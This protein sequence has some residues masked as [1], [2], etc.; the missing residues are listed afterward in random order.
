MGTHAVN[1][2]EMA[3][4][5]MVLGLLL[6]MV[7]SGASA[8]DEPEVILIASHE[9]EEA[10]ASMA[11][12]VGGQLS[13]LPVTFRVEWVDGFEPLMASQVDEARALAK[14]SDAVAVIWSDLSDPSQV[15]IYIAEPHG[16]RILVRSVEPEGEVM[17]MLVEALAVIVRYAVE[18][19]IEG[20]EIGIKPPPVVKKELIEKPSH[21][22][23]RLGVA[24][25]YALSLYGPD[26][27]LLH[28][29]RVA[30]EVGIYR[31]LRGYIGYRIQPSMR[32]GDH[33]LSMTMNTHP[34]EIGI[35]M[36]IEKGQFRFEGG[37]GVVLDRLTWTVTPRDASIVATPPSARW[38]LGVSPYVSVGWAPRWFASMYFAVSL[39]IY[40][41]EKRYVVASDVESWTVVA[42]WVVRPLFQLGGSFSFF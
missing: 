26:Q 22:P 40:G 7:P 35:G 13:D 8:G 10:S 34:M 41:N 29:A 32:F 1:G 5:A 30:L 18:A 25:S 16:E 23:A 15:F 6:A 14:H 11:D 39:D 9:T 42:P 19:M 2:R 33:L 4:P 21:G 37:A 27:P 36:R 17:P 28:G 3:L 38:L 20:G 24:V 12:A 31:W